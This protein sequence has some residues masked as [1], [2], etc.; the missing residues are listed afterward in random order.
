MTTGAAAARGGVANEADAKA[1][2]TDLDRRFSLLDADYHEMEPLWQDLASLIRPTRPRFT[3]YATS[4]GVSRRNNNILRAVAT[5]ASRTARAGLLNGLASPARPWVAL[6]TDLVNPDDESVEWLEELSGAVLTSYEQNNLYAQLGMMLADSLDFATGLLAAWD[7]DEKLA[8]YQTFPVGSFR[9][10]NDFRGRVN[11]FARQ[12]PST[13]AQVVERFG[14]ATVTQTVRDHYSN[15]R[16][17]QKLNVRHLIAS[18]GTW[19]KWQSGP[20]EAP[21]AWR[22]VYWEGGF[23][24][25]KKHLP[26]GSAGPPPSIPVVGHGVLMIGGFHEFPVFAARWGRSHDDTYGMSS[27]GID[28]LGVN[29]SLQAME[30]MYLTAVE[31]MTDPPLL[32]GDNMKNKAVSGLPRAVTYDDSMTGPKG[33]VRPLYQVNTP[34]QL[35][36]EHMKEYAKEIEAFYYVDLFRAIID[37]DR[38]QPETAQAV[39]A[40]LGERN[41]LIGPTM[42]TFYDEVIDP[43]VQRTV[44]QLMR[45]AGPYW[46]R[47]QDSPRLSRP[48]E[49][50]QGSELKV[51]Y[52]SEIAQSLRL[53]GLEPIERHV[54]F[55]AGLAQIV[56]EAQATLAAKVDALVAE[57]ASISGVPRRLQ[58][59]EDELAMLRQRE[60]QAAAAA[61]AAEQAP[62]RAKAVKDLSQ[63]QVGGE[64]VLDQLVSAGADQ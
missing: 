15:G 54:G 1:M 6:R 17:D 23:A 60:A 62:G 53:A 55:V 56:P 22:E 12:F 33:G 63:A 46:A 48:P 7:D 57:H 39:R 64:S 4:G 29:G 37:Y 30:E 28:S 40:K 26:A 41:A 45:E 24:E 27:P 3:K 36:S 5:L 52:T 16:Y 10:G 18:A 61:Q 34:I 58:P 35:L 50:L 2:R 8:H 59:T 51:Q 49:A 11:Q 9:L 38:A 31:K 20:H 47:G 13:V 25:G 32:A 42:Q 44:A 43:L 14:I 19:P 21:W